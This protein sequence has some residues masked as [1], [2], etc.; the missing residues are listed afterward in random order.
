MQWT[1]WI[2]LAV[3]MV[4]VTTGKVSPPP[5][6]LDLGPVLPT[7]APTPK[8]AQRKR[9]ITT[10][11]VQNSA[12][13]ETTVSF[14]ATDIAEE[15]S[16]KTHNIASKSYSIAEAEEKPELREARSRILGQ[17]REL[18]HELLKFAE[19]SGPPKE[20]AP[21]QPGEQSGGGRPAR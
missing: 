18:E 15:G 8:H 21:L 16:G 20:R 13:G 19:T 7:P 1:S 3:G 17:I 11:T 6:M 12:E 2:G 5:V 9:L 14:E 4:M 10:I